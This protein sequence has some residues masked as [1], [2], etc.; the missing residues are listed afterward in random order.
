MRKLTT[1][2]KRMEKRT[3]AAYLLKCSGIPINIMDIS[4][5]FDE[6]RRLQLEGADDKALCDGILAFVQRLAKVPA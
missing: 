1:A 2:E 3:N 4:K 6:G 5:V